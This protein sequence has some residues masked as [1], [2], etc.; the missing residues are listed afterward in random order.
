M[1]SENINKWLNDEIRL[2]KIDTGEFPV[3]GP[4]LQEL[5][6]VHGMSKPQIKKYLIENDILDD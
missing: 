5:Q 3:V 2:D 1:E 4:V 6:E